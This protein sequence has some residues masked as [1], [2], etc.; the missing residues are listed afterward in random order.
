MMI[1]IIFGQKKIYKSW[2]GA[3]AFTTWNW[4]VQNRHGHVDVDVDVDIIVNF[5][6][7]VNVVQDHEVLFGLFSENQH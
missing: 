3:F 5:D 6:V 2:H 1:M 4:R 7:D